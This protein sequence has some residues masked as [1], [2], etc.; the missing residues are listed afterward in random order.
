MWFERS[1]LLRHTNLT[2]P[3]GELPVRTA[4]RALLTARTRPSR[5]RASRPRCGRHEAPEHGRDGGVATINLRR[6]S[7][8]RRPGRTP[9]CAWRAKLHRERNSRT[10]TRCTSR[11]RAARSRRSAASGPGADDSRQLLTPRTGDRRPH[12]GDRRPPHVERSRDGHVRRVRGRHGREGAE[13]RPHR[14]ADDVRRPAAAG[15]RVGDDDRPVLGVRHVVR[16]RRGEVPTA[17]GAT[18]R[19][20]VAAAIRWPPEFSTFTT[21]AA[22]NTSDVPV[23]RRLDV[24]WAPINGVWTTIAGSEAGEVRPRH[25]GRDRDAA[26][27]RDRAARD[28]EGPRARWGTGSR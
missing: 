21:M 6:S 8:R 10:F 22:S 9:G 13:R 5:P 17:A 11:S 7:P 28:L 12:A 20:E 26:D 18:A 14:D 27:R 16:D 4:V 2:A 25:V 24:R 23:T 1:G 3:A 19:Q 15:R